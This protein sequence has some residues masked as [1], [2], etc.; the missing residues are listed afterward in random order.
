MSLADGHLLYND[1]RFD[2]ALDWIE[3]R[4]T[5]PAQSQP[6]HV[7]RRMATLLPGWGKPP[8]V[9]ADTEAAS[10]TAASFVFR[11]QN[12]Q[13]PVVFMNDI[14]KL[15]TLADTPILE[16]DVQIL[17]IEVAIDAYSRIQ[18]DHDLVKMAHHFQRHHARPPAGPMRITG[19]DGHGEIAGAPALVQQALAKGFTVNAGGATS[20]HR[21]RYYVKRFDT[22]V[23]GPYAAL[24]SPEHRARMEVTLLGAE[25]PFATLPGWREFAFDSLA[26]RLALRKA[27]P[28]RTP[29]G[30]L[31]QDRM[32]NIGQPDDEAKRRAH[33]R[34]HKPATTADTEANEK[35]R[36]A[37]RGLTRRQA[38]KPARAP[39]MDTSLPEGWGDW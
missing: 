38:G 12:P 18:D 39:K 29:T 2:A 3:V 22:G 27:V 6:Q 4:V 1:F 34:M 11:V 19:P 32:S 31:L 25:S 36:T 30:Q 16:H 37:L 26:K 7:R 17:G 5:L 21:S 23:T 10:R 20:D 15:S 14:Q 35:V 13:S 24:P 9:R 33:Q 8:Y 28:S